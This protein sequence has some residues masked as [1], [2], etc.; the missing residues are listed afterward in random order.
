MGVQNQVL[1]RGKIFFDPFPAGSFVGS[2]ERYLGNTPSCATRQSLAYVDEFD[3][4]GETVD[5]VERTVIRSDL[6]VAFATDNIVAEN[7]AMWAQADQ[8]SRND[9]ALDSQTFIATVFPDRYYQIGKTAA[10]PLGARNTVVTYA[11]KTSDN[12][13]LLVGVNFELDRPNGR[14]Y[15]KDG[16]PNIPTTGLQVTF[17]YSTGAI[18]GRQVVKKGTRVRGALRFV[19]DNAQGQNGSYFWPYVVISPDSDWIL[20]SD[21]WQKMSFSAQVLRV[22]TMGQ[23]YGEI[24]V[25]VAGYTHDEQSALTFGTSDQIIDWSNQLYYTTNVQEPSL[26]SP[27]Q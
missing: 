21:D 9:A 2:G 19:A 13:P 23:M 10:N 17:T 11:A 5:M 3:S 18:T 7:A 6:M 14:I 4:F 15:V 1:G 8:V 25:G 22:G 12:S 24:E 16:A 20:K 26:G 27:H